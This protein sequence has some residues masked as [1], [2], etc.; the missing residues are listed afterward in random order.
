MAPQ[1][2]QPAAAPPVNVS[3]VMFNFQITVSGMASCLHSLH[4]LH[5]RLDGHLDPQD[6][7][8]MLQWVKSISIIIISGHMISPKF[9]H[10][11]PEKREFNC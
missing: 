11:V 8:G 9:I 1:L 4:F 7:S 6:H 10:C 3:N 2:S 5:H